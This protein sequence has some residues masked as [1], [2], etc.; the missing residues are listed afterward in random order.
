MAISPLVVV[1]VIE[2]EVPVPVAEVLFCQPVVWSQLNR[3]T[4]PSTTGLEVPPVHETDRVCAPVAGA[5]RPKKKIES[6]P[7]VTLVPMAVI[8]VPPHVIA[9]A[10]GVMVR[11]PAY[12]I[13]QR[14]EFAPTDPA[15]VPALLTYEKGEAEFAPFSNFVSSETDA[16]LLSE[17]SNRMGKNRFNY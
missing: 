14:L 9:T 2:A 12:P 5:I 15:T 17:S 16:K 1:I 4:A 10:D 8:D 6:V 13:R 11:K 7:S 3:L